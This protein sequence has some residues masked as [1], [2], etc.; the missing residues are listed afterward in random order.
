VPVKA[1]RSNRSSRTN[2][3]RQHRKL[4][5]VELIRKLIAMT[6]GSALILFGL[7]TF[8]IPND[9]IYGDVVGL[10][11]IAAELS[12]LPIG[13]FLIIFYV[14]LL[15][16]GYKQIGKTF[17]WSTA[18][19]VLLISVGT[20][21]FKDRPPVTLD[22]LLA[23]V[24]GA[25]IVGVGVGLIVRSGGS[26]DGTETL[27]VQLAKQFPF[28]IDQLVM[29]LNIFILGSAGFVFGW[30]RA[31]YALIAYFIAFKMIAITLE[32]F[33][34][35]KSVWVIS[36]RSRE[37]G[38]IIDSRLGRNVTYLQGTGGYSGHSK[39]VIFVVITRLEEAKLKSIVVELD[40]FAFLAVGNIHD[41]KGGLFKKKDIH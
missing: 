39:E 2:R 27:A 24:F 17:T 12:E 7:E 8:L 30:D 18:Y 6:L 40:P 14:P 23:A 35:S 21:V 25:I 33:D 9:I 29:F 26:I 19:T 1:L 20:F 11:I 16:I 28:S 22:P 37:I 31:M 13:L 36:D 15:F 3:R 34:Q 32:G 10:S 5:P 41:V 4:T 38:P